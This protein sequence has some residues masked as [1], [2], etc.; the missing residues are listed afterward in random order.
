M[1]YILIFE[2]Q[3]FGNHDFFGNRGQHF[4]FKGQNCYFFVF[5]SQ[6]LSNFGCKVK[7]GLYFDF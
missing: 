7:N 2:G 4:R 1:V 6:N 5:S 3:N